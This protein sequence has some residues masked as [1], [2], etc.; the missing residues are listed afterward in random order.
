MDVDE[1][2]QRTKPKAVRSRLA[3][4]I[5]QIQILKTKGYT[6]QQV[7]EWL[8]TNEVEISLESVRVFVNKHI[9]KRPGTDKESSNFTAND[10]KDGTVNTGGQKDDG[11]ENGLSLRQRGEKEAAKYLNKETLSP[12]SK[13]LLAKAK[14]NK[15]ESSSD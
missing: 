10:S 7:Q 14:E 3:P 2:I 13:R 12:L 5:E 1:Y 9:L 4:F 11:S 6:N 15:D 8:E